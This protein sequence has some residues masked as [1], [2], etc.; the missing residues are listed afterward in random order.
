MDKEV[1]LYFST[2]ILNIL[3]SRIL[4]NN[5]LDRCNTHLRDLTEMLQLL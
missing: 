3:N 5:N 1:L 2:N 4:C